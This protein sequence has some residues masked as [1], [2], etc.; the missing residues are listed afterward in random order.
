MTPDDTTSTAGGDLDGVELQPGT[1]FADRYEI[2]RQLGEGGFSSVYLATDTHLGGQGAPVALKVFV[3]D[4]SATAVNEMTALS[5]LAH[6][7][8]VSVKHVESNH[9][10]PYLIMEYLDGQPLSRRRGQQLELDEIERIG[11]QL[12]NA[13]VTLH[14]DHE[15][16]SDSKDGS[17]SLL[18]ATTRPRIVHRDIKPENVLDDGETAKLID[19]NIAVIGAS[20][21]RS[22]AHSHHYVP[23]DWDGQSVSTDLDLY[24]LG[25]VLYEL[26]CG[27]RPDEGFP[28][29]MADPL[30]HRSTISPSHRDFLQRACA[31]SAIDRFS[32]ATEMAE[33][34]QKAMADADRYADAREVARADLVGMITRMGRRAGVAGHP[35]LLIGSLQQELPQLRDLLHEAES[36]LRSLRVVAPFAAEEVIRSARTVTERLEKETRDDPA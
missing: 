2:E 27:C 24:A 9:R 33:A 23:P 17:L 19:F 34:F 21:T 5:K 6:P 22:G 36:I 10:P 35:S 16:S 8:I 13:V 18:E 28:G 29:P 12:L 1:I 30:T 11:T 26:S 4:R 3:G 15:Y 32:S 7:N 25:V 20:P 31:A 14:Q